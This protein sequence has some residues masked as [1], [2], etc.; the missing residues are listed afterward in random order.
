MYP[1]IDTQKTIFILTL[2]DDIN[3]A[4]V[5]STSDFEFIILTLLTLILT[6]L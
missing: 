4:N 3:V 1:I 6:T 2:F 5:T